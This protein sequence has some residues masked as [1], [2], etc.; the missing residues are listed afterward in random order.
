MI[1]GKIYSPSNYNDKYA[2]AVGIAIRM[3]S[4]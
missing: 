4:D 3:L 2:E 1:D